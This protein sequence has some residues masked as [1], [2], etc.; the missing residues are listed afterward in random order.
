V[1]SLSAYFPRLIDEEGRIP[2]NKGIWVG[3]YCE[4]TEFALLFLVYFLAR[5]HHPEAFA[6]GPLRLATVAGTLNTLLMVT[7]S[8]FVVRSVLAM[9]RDRALVTLRW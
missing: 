5:A 2:G 4:M 3:I 9:R 6:D 7:S 8:W 1:A